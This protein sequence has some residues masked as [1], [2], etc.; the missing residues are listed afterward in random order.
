MRTEPR[1]VLMAWEI[2]KKWMQGMSLMHVTLAAYGRTKPHP[3]AWLASETGQGCLAKT[4]AT[5]RRQVI[6][7]PGECR[8]TEDEDG[9]WD[10]R[11]R[12]KHVLLEGSPME[13]RMRFCCYC[14]RWLVERRRTGGR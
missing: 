4:E 12:Q 5:I 13:N 7:R 14:G 9:N 10:T 8:W 11:C 2:G 6:A 3:L 1:R